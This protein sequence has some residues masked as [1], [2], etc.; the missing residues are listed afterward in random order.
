MRGLCLGLGLC[1]KRNLVPSLNNLTFSSTAFTAGTPSSGTINGATAGSTI[2]ATGL[3]SGLT[4]NGAARTW[5]WDGTGTAGTGSFTLTET[6]AGYVNSP[7]DSTVGYT[8]AAAGGG[9][10]ANAITFNGASL[11]YSGQELTYA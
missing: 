7:R 8:I 9:P 3:P 4:I 10:A 11:T 1:G 6:L 2:T 5:A